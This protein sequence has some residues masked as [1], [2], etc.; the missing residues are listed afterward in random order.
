MHVYR[1]TLLLKLFK[2]GNPAIFKSVEKPGDAMLKVNQP[3][4]SKECMI[5]LTYGCKTSN[6]QKHRAERGQ[7]GIMEGGQGD[8]SGRV[9]RFWQNITRY[10]D[11]S[12]SHN[13]I[14][15]ER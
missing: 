4:R 2:E 3:P 6:S 15:E 10:S 7:Q 14:L 1:C 8:I 11:S 12:D 5:P 9:Q 13:C